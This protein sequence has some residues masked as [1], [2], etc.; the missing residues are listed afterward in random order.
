VNVELARQHWLEGARR[1][2]S[3]RGDPRR[4]SRLHD[5][6]ELV[7]AELRRRVGR[8]F[9]LAELARVYEGAEDWA[10]ALLEEARPD[11]T[12][13]PDAVVAADAAF[14]LYARGAAD[15]SP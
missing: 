2:E 12:P 13:P 15:Y 11:D 14:H 4:Y 8:T 5:E 9:T 10:R 6:V 7:V 1:L 3:T